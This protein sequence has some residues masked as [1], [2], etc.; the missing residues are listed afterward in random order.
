[1]QRITKP[2]GFVLATILGD[3]MSRD[4]DAGALG[5]GRDGDELLRLGLHVWRF[6]PSCTEWWIRTHW[7]RAFDIHAV[8]L[9]GF[10][11]DSDSGHGVVLM[12]PK[13]VSLTVD[14]LVRYEPGEQRYAK[15]WIQNLR[16]LDADGD[17]LR[18]RGGQP[19]TIINS[20]SWRLTA[21]PWALGGCAPR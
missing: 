13:D 4:L 15:A 10:A 8:Q 17:M 19:D 12:S 18:E 3:A 14:D 21:S 9:N 6:A 11:N 7:G 2:G 5:R 16:Q 20:R 1:M